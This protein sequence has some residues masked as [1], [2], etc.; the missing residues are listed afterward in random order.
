MNKDD[1]DEVILIGGCTRIPKIQ[2][3]LKEFF[4]NKQIK[5][6]HKDEAIA[7]GAAIQAA[8]I[9]NVGHKFIR[10]IVLLEVTPLSFG[11]EIDEDSMAVIIPRNSTIPSKKTKIFYNIEDNQFSFVVNIFEGESGLTK[12]NNF[13]GKIELNGIPPMPKGKAKIEVTF[14]VDSFGNLNVSLKELS[15]GINNKR[16]F[17]NTKNLFSKEFINEKIK[18]FHNYEKEE[19]E[20]E[21]AK[22]N[23]DIYFYSIKQMIKD[24]KINKKFSENDKNQIQIK[25]DEIY[26]WINNNV[27]SSKEEYK[28]KIKEI[29]AILNPI[30][31]NIYREDNEILIKK[32]ENEFELKNQKVEEL[33][34]LEEKI[35]AINFISY[36]EKIIYPM[37]CK[38]SDIFSKLE[39][40][41][42]L[43]YPEYK[44]QNNYFK[45]NGKKINKSETLEKNRI[46]NGD[47]IF[48]NTNENL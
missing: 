34:N 26:D 44:S 33:N 29:E 6:S 15:T 16:V 45:I 35:I 19:K 23:F 8:I 18:E 32:E 21:E 38:G 2:T 22:I 31:K 46:K 27:I 41:L 42:Y 47:I 13:L 3:M 39:E 11:I 7:Y 48:L 12:N 24:I 17:S 36:D 40:K 14:D 37:A 5:I 25:I 28:N 30:L 20:K 9:S 10:Q 1:L 43:E 4:D